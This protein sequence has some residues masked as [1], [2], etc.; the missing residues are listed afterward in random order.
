MIWAQPT[1]GRSM[2]FV[3]IFSI[4]FNTQKQQELLWQL[5]IDKLRQPLTEQTIQIWWAY[6]ALTHCGTSCRSSPDAIWNS[7]I[8]PIGFVW[9]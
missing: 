2:E 4:E 1:G 6:R 3:F 9:T 7:F 5:T 8:S